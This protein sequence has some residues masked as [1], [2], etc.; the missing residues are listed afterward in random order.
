MSLPTVYLILI[1]L[2]FYFT[3]FV[4]QSWGEFTAL[5]WPGQSF[6]TLDLGM[7]QVIEYLCEVI[8][9]SP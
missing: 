9:Y 5:P 2:L 8:A 6:S 1:S 7:G 4:D 3:G